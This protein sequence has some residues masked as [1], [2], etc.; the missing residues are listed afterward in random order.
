M[1]KISC[2]VASAVEQRFYY[3]HIAEFHAARHLFIAYMQQFYRFDHIIGKI[4]VERAG[5]ASACRLVEFWKTDLK[6]FVHHLAPV[7]HNVKKKYGYRIGESIQYA[8]RQMGRSAENGFKY[9]HHILMI[10]GFRL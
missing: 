4:A 10:S 2:H 6:I 8:E 3:L 5:Y 7:A 9:A 1:G